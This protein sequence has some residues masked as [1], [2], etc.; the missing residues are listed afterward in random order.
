MSID[1]KNGVSEERNREQTIVSK[2]NNRLFTKSPYRLNNF[3]LS[4]VDGLT[5]ILNHFQQPL[6]PRTISTKAT[7]GRQVVVSSREEALAYYTAA[8]LLDCRISAY[9]SAAMKNPSVVGRFAGIPTVTARNIAIMIDLDRQNFKTDSG[10]NSALS[11]TLQ[12]INQLESNLIPTIIWS[13]R[14][15]HIIVVLDSNNVNL[16]YEKI[17]AD[18]TSQP[19]RDFLRFAESFLSSGKSDRCHNTTVS[20]NNCMLRIPGSIN[21]KNG[22]HVELLYKWNDIKPK[23]NYLL[24][25]F[26][27]YLADQRSQELIAFA[28]AKSKSSIKSDNPNYALQWIEN[29]LQTP[30]ANGRKY[31]IWRILTPY[32]INRKKY[33]AEQCENIINTWL[34]KCSSLERISFNGR[35]KINDCIRRVE[36]FGPAHPD[37]LR[38]E[39]PE[40]YDLLTEYGVF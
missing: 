19:S 29:L 11:K 16:E 5:Y 10:L 15:Y 36:E 33:S 39:Y 20:F 31:C 4:V 35:Q 32:L 13:G 40:L 3:S 8:N 38:Q 17:F 28:K 23:I 30:I 2:V 1:D 21:S 12:K 6:W 34:D 26:C 18:M 22:Q 24:S 27:I 7:K 37:K 14:G 25:D 9:P